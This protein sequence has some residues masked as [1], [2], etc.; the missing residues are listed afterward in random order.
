[1]G[2]HGNVRHFDEVTSVNM[3]P[4]SINMGLNPI[5]GVANEQNEIQAEIKPEGTA[6]S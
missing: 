5:T 4:N 3:W 2:N 1:M 6:R